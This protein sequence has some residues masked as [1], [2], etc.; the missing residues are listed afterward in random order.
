MSVS[1]NVALIHRHELRPT[2]DVHIATQP[3]ARE[4]AEFVFDYMV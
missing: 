2:Y 3:R 1:L 4:T